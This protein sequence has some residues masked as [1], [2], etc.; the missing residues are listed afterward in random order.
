MA[1]DKQEIYNQAMKAIKEHELF[2]MEDVSAYVPCSRSTFYSY[3]PDGSD[4][5]DTLKGILEENKI[6]KKTAIRAKL[7]KG[8]KA[9]ELLALYRL[10]CTDDER[11]ALS[12][13]Y[14][15]VESEVN[16]NQSVS[17]TDDQLDKVLE[18]IKPK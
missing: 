16:T 13:S 2:F 12:M 14:Q 7:F 8:E 17:L 9:A 15:K 5:L 4:E 10:I 6:K 18:Q 11:R 1:Y 3:Y